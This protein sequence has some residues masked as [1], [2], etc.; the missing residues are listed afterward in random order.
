MLYM[1]I[2]LFFSFEIYLASWARKNKTLVE[3]V[4][5]NLQSIFSFTLFVTQ[6][7]IK[8]NVIMKYTYV[9]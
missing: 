3:T 9:I 6:I 7:T 1:D 2:H 4:D 8:G 5:V